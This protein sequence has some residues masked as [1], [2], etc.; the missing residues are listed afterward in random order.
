MFA[1]ET[2]HYNRGQHE[3]LAGTS[4]R[5]ISHVIFCNP[6]NKT[7]PYKGVSC[8]ASLAV[9]NVLRFTRP[10]AQSRSPL[11]KV[12]ICLA[13]GVFMPGARPGVAG[14]LP[15]L[16]LQITVLWFWMCAYTLAGR[17]LN[18]EL[19]AVVLSDS[20]VRFETDISLH[21]SQ[22]S[23]L[24]HCSWTTPLHH[25]AAA[26]TIFMLIEHTCLALFPESPYVILYLLALFT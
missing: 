14:C 4:E 2:H 21:D 15:A 11:F 24:S 26:T 20:S 9:L 13:S 23:Q 8:T 5:L 17:C 1:L 25:A 7:A 19:F 3:Q 6:S 18:T 22:R 12:V 16:S 10:D